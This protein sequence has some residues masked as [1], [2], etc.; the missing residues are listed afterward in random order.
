MASPLL[1]QLS[2]VS[3]W[4]WP[5]GFGGRM[6]V[7]GDVTQ[8]SIGLMAVLARSLRAWRLPLWNDLWGYGFPGV[9]ESQMGVFYPPHWLLYG[10]LPLETAYTASLVAHTLW[11]SLG[12]YWCARVFGVS[13]EGSALS[14]FAWSTS[15]F[16]LIHLSHQWGYTTG[17]WMP[18]AWGLA[19]LTLNGRQRAARL[20]LVLALQL[21]PGHFSS[22]SAPRSGWRF[23]RPGR[24]ANGG[25][26][27]SSR[28]PWSSRHSRGRS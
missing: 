27:H 12:A 19:W 4:L 1:I 5:I 3:A 18:W 8:F 26:L 11:G 13:R 9:G 24:W 22:R 17:C 25:R 6:P 10:L 23:S 21:L 15:G 28:R 7:G 16:F 20:A 2:A 14:G